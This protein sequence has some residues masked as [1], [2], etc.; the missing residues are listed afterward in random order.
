M[1]AQLTRKEFLAEFAKYT[2]GVI[3]GS[4]G[5]NVLM[6]STGKAGTAVT[7][8]PWPYRALDVEHVRIL[9]HDSFYDST[10]GGGCGYGAFNAIIQALREV[11]GDPYTSL[12][13]Q[14]MFFGHGGA[15]EWGT[16]CGGLN[17]AAAAIS[18]VCNKADSDILISELLG[19]YTQVKL[20][21]DTSNQYAVDNKY[22][23]NK[24][25][26]PLL[27]NSSGSPLCH[28][29][30]SEWCKVA[31][32]SADDPNRKE[33]CARLTGD[34]AAY[35]AQILNDFYAGK[36]TPLYV[37]PQTIAQ[38]TVCHSSANTTP[39]TTKGKMECTQCHGNP[40]QTGS[41]LE[42]G[43]MATSY[44]LHQNYPNPFNPSTNIQFSI[45][46]RET[47]NLAVYDVH[48]RLV[49][50]LIDNESYG[51]GNYKV[52]WNGINSLGER[53]ASGI[54]FARLQAGSFSKTI[55]MSLV[56]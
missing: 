23:V 7:T 38:C 12:P 52:N 13:S 5:L 42:V 17:G 2:A 54:Y 35:A 34:V 30:V 1:S 50:Q 6:K 55:K 24:I 16:L 11:V 22:G 4:A 20:P 32:F 19:W 40:H 53:V 48:G 37:P 41:V 27:Q 33:R 46:H 8:W 49:A 25:S 14:L 9:G 51:P 39:P 15:A 18:L 45:P 31:G 21:T 10:N 56:R 26:A 44:S 28:V 29:S 47:V 43:G 36:F 3:V